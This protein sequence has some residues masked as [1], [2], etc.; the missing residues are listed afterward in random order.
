MKPLATQR[1]KR[2]WVYLHGYRVA[3]LKEPNRLF[4]ICRY[5]HQHKIIDAGG[6][7]I[8]ETTLSTS[9]TARHLSQKKRGHGYLPPGKE[10]EKR[11]ISHLRRVLI[12][13]KISVSQD[14]ANEL[15]GFN[16]QH[17]RLAAVS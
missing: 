8:Y 1:A 12:G 5:C 7:G 9:T 10:A 14:I 17:F 11:E 6:A 4:F 13:D 15:S 16:T 3:L 2:S